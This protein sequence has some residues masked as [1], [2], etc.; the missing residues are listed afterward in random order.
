MEWLQEIL[1]GIENSPEVL[2]RIKQELPKH[3]IPKDKYNDLA[4]EKRLLEEAAQTADLDTLKGFA[5]DFA[6]K[7]LSG[8]GIPRDLTLVKGLI[9]LQGIEIGADGNVSGVME[10]IDAMKKEKPFLFGGQG[11]AGRSPVAVGGDSLSVTREQFEKMSY[12]EK[13]EVYEQSPELYKQLI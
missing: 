2:T 6:L 1:K 7:A 13:M 11:L 8:D 3:F 4:Q 9:D 10:Q 5:V 12:R